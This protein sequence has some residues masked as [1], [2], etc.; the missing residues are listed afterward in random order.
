MNMH[1]LIPLSPFTFIP[2]IFILFAYKWICF[3]IECSANTFARYIADFT[4]D[5]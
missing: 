3:M 2:L 5:F 4:Y 1:L